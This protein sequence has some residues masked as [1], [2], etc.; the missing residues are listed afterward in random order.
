MRLYLAHHGIAILPSVDMQRSLSSD[1]LARVE[2][3][4]EK[5]AQR[6]VRPSVV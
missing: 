6:G 2:H 1:G 3:L 4:A 5:A